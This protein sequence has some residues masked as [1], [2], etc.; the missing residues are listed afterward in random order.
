[1]PSIIFE[2]KDQV[3]CITLNRPEKLN[4]FNRDMAI[5]LQEKLDECKSNKNIRTAYI[6]GSGKGF[7]AGQDLAE[8]VDPEGPGMKRILS[9]HYNP[10]V[11]RI[12]KLDKPVV[13]AVN[14]VAAGAGANIAFCCDIVVAAHSASFFKSFS[15]M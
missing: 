13:C 12:R 7:S 15:K 11:T 6:T 14:G 5:L 8:V 4:A 2:I 1:M 3:G 10:I 9:E